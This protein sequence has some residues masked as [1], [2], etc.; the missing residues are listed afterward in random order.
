MKELNEDYAYDLM[1]LSENQLRSVHFFLIKKNNKYTNEDFKWFKEVA[2]KFK[3]VF[4][5]HRL[6][7]WFFSSQKGVK[8]VSNGLELFEVENPKACC[9]EKIAEEVSK[10]KQYQIGIDT[11]ERSKA[12]LTPENILSIC[13]F[14]I[15]KYTWRKKNQ[16]IE[17]F[18]KVIYYANWAIETLNISKTTD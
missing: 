7:R 13:Q 5:I 3:G 12:N 8:L 18:E 10:P 4:L 1:G 9:N 11:I 15:D 16:D 14:Q 6:N 17:D 2:S